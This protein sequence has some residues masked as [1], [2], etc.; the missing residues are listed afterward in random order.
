MIEGA[1]GALGAVGGGVGMFAPSLLDLK[2]A[3]PD[4]ERHR[5]DMY[6]GIAL[7]SVWS[8]VIVAAIAAEKRSAQP[9]V[10]WGAG[11]VAVIA[12]H[13]YMRRDTRSING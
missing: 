6:E 10:W 8:L 7:G 5:R 2:H 11:L 4:D 12:V 9:F 3:D 1:S 13:E